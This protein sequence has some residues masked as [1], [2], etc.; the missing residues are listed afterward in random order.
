MI[1]HMPK[2]LFKI[3]FINVSLSALSY[4]IHQTFSRGTFL[5]LK[6]QKF[7]KAP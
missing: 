3:E 1:P 6:W 7:K 5:V 2:G 4:N